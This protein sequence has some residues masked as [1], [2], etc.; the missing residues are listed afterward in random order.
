MTKFVDTAR[1]GATLF[2]ACVLIAASAASA[3]AA[4]DKEKT[5]DAAKTAAGSVRVCV[6]PEKITGSL[7][8][9]PRKCK[10]RDE[11]IKDTGIDP[12]AKR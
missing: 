3:S 10:T 7:I 11:W 6:Q 2:G 8:A 1:I 5:Q 12:L 9:P 4:S